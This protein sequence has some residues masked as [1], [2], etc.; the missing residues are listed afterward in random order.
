MPVP[1]PVP[2]TLSLYSFHH[3]GWYFACCS[4]PSH[5]THILKAAGLM[6]LDK[7]ERSWLKAREALDNTYRSQQ[8]RLRSA[9]ETEFTELLQS[10]L[11][12]LKRN[13]GVDASAE[14]RV[15]DIAVFL[16][17]CKS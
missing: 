2:W 13:N 4:D 17:T 14:I 6:M 3:G 15:I 11:E 12:Q 1:L 9:A 8:E 10:C 5:S 7:L 16:R